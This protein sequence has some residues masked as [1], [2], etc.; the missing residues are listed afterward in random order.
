MKAVSQAF[1]ACNRRKGAVIGIIPG[2]WEAGIYSNMPGYPNDWIEIPVFT[3][4]PYSGTSG[5][6][7]ESR[8]H[9]N[10]LTSDVIVILP[11][12]AG[13]ASEA[14]LAVRYRKPAIA[15]LDD[16]SDIDGLPAEIPVA[17]EFKQVKAFIEDRI[18]GSHG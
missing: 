15:W 10:V 18:G 5:T 11:G 8:N 2:K 9:I 16:R 4:L 13:T 14:R 17:R 6:V 3:H 1:A 7:A 12:S